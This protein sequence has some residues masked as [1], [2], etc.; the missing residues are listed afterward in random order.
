MMTMVRFA[1]LALTGALLAGCVVAPAA[2][3]GGHWV[4]G[5][6]GPGGAWHPGHWA[7]GYGGPPPE[8]LEAPGG[9][10]AGRVW[11]PGFYG[12]GGAWH[13]GHWAAG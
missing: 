6:Y 11:V 1:A 2:P 7:G 13:P 8:A 9:Y 12:P 3:P 10:G 4:A 5:Y